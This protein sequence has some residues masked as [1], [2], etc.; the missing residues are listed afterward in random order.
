MDDMLRHMRQAAALTYLSQHCRLLSVGA[1][2]RYLNDSETGRATI[3]VR[4]ITEEETGYE[5]SS[6]IPPAPHRALALIAD[7]R[8]EFD[9][10]ISGGKTEEE[11]ERNLADIIADQVEQEVGHR[12]MARMILQL[13][14][15]GPKAALDPEVD[16]LKAG[17]VDEAPAPRQSIHEL[18]ELSSTEPGST[19]WRHSWAPA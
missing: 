5:L 14:R 13:R 4:L 18:A 8:G 19:S 7:A 3:W 9:I 1:N 12:G 17:Q 15:W 11:A 10:I 6:T 2:F 16:E